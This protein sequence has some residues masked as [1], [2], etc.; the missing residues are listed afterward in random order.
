MAQPP[1][2]SQEG[3]TLASWLS[4]SRFVA[5]KYINAGVTPRSSDDELQN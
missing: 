5:P 2:L 3:S 1:L 4:L